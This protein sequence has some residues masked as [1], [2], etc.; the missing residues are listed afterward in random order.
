MRLLPR[1]L[2]VIIASSAQ[3]TSSRGLAAWSGPTA[4]PIESVSRPDGVELRERD[5]LCDPLGER[6]GDLEVAR[7]EDDR[8]LL[9]AGPAHVVALA[10]RRPELVGELGQHLVSD[11][12]PVDVVDPLEVVEVEHHERH[13]PALGR[14]CERARCGVAR[15][16]RGGSRAR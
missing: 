14:G 4:I 6:L 13:R 12:V 10:H 11:G 1:A 5:P 15:G 7:R 3:A 9:A 16:R 8:E 2:A